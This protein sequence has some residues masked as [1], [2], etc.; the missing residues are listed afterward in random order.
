MGNL[1]RGVRDYHRQPGQILHSCLLP[2]FIMGSQ[3]MVSDYYQ[4]CCVGHWGGLQHSLVK[5]M[6]KG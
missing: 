1:P 5:L 6:G 3:P 2:E 4:F